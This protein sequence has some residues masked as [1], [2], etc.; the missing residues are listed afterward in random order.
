MD[1]KQIT[2]FEEGKYYS[3]FDKRGGGIQKIA[4]RGVLPL[5]EG[6]TLIGE[7]QNG[8]ITKLDSECNKYFDKVKEITEKEFIGPLRL[9]VGKYYRM[10]RR[11]G[12]KEEYKIISL[13]RTKNGVSSY[14]AELSSGELDIAKFFCGNRSFWEEITEE[15]FYASES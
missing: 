15:E 12:A 10:G 11:S 13:I 9:E 4:V 6:N 2:V 3:Y 7:W 8:L 1:N 14:A 5:L